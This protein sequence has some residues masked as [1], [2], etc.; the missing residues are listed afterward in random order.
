MREKFSH[1]G[2]MNEFIVCGWYTEDARWVLL[3]DLERFSHEH[4]FRELEK[5]KDARWED[6]TVLK[7]IAIMERRTRHDDP[8]VLLVSG[9]RQLRRSR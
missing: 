9:C 6:V 8:V 2:L 7:P 1:T 5:P 3:G 4:D